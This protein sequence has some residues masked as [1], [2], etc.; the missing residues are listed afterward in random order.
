MPMNTD[1][2][3]L[4]VDLTTG[5]I[6]TETLSED[7]YKRYPGGKALAGY[8][9]LKEMPANTEPFDPENLLILA[10]GLLTGAPVSTTTRYVVAGRSPLTYAVGSSEAGGYWGPELKQAGYEAIII[11]GRAEKPGRSVQ[12]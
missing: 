10:A 3:I 4:R 12:R 6:Q 8:Y 11:T 5:N 1:W 2:K 7:F 9:L